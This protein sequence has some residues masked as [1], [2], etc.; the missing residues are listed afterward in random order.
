[1]TRQKPLTSKQFIQI[2]YARQK[3][4]VVNLWNDYFPSSSE[5]LVRSGEYVHNSNTITDRAG[6]VNKKKAPAVGEHRS[7]KIDCLKKTT[8]GAKIFIPYLKKISTN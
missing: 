8:A 6:G 1:L 2:L 3:A 4:S 5:V 7:D